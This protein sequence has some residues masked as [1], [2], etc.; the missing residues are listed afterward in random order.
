MYTGDV[1][2]D[3]VVLDGDDG[4]VVM[5][6]DGDDRLVVMGAQCGG[7]RRQANHA[8]CMIRCCWRRHLTIFGDVVGVGVCFAAAAAAA[9]AHGA[10]DVHRD[11][12][13]DDSH[14]DAQPFAQ[15]QSERVPIKKK[16]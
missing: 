15:G 11:D 3:C 1:Q 13:D 12:K 14:D 10:Y 2:L 4:L 7:W 5:V 9:T 8:T 6:L 16:S